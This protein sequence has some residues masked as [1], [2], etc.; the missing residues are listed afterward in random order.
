MTNICETSER[1]LDVY[2]RC[3]LHHLDLG[4]SGTKATKQPIVSHFV[5]KSRRNTLVFQDVYPHVLGTDKVK[6]PTH[7]YPHRVT[8]FGCY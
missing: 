4:V 7:H 3:D 2:K 5:I 6:R 1:R 8:L